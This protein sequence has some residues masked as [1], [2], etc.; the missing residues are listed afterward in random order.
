ME[1]SKRSQQFLKK[2]DRY[3]KSVTL[4]YKKSGVFET[5]VGGCCSIF[6]FILLAYWLIVNVFYALA[7]NGSFTKSS[8]QTLTQESDGSWPLYQL[9]GYNLFVAYKF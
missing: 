3:A 9:S 6:S 7:N 5:S 8:E 4:T 1:R 2:Y